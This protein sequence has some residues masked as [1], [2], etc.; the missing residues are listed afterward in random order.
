MC[1]VKGD[2]EWLQSPSPLTVISPSKTLTRPVKGKSAFIGGG[3]GRNLAEWLGGETKV[4]EKIKKE[5]K[6]R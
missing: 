3:W 4:E 1:E 5:G 2:L 6:S